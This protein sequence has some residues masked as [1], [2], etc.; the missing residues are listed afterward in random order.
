VRKGEDRVTASVARRRRGRERIESEKGSLSAGDGFDSLIDFLLRGRLSDDQ[1]V[2]GGA[3]GHPGYRRDHPLQ[4]PESTLLLEGS[5]GRSRLVLER[6]RESAKAAGASVMA[7]RRRDGRAM[8]RE[9]GGGGARGQAEVGFGRDEL[10]LIVGGL[11]ISVHSHR[12]TH[13]DR[14]TD[15]NQTWASPWN[16][17]TD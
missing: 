15:G 13:A 11:M 9:D 6:E 12:V 4:D 2:L 16:S 1:D 5:R 7:G 17:S 10:G 3:L 14:L 8:G